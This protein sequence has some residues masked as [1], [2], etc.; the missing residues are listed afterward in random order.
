MRALTRIVRAVALI[1]LFLLFFGFAL[2]NTEPVTVR[3]FLGQ[4]WRA[5]LSLVLLV[6]F[7]AGAVL[8]VLASLTVAYRQRREL[9]QLRRRLALE[10]QPTAASTALPDTP[11][12]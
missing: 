12:V 3:Y 11:I 6:F 7:G 4:E 5:A 2:K 9:A 10:P 8:G 1:V